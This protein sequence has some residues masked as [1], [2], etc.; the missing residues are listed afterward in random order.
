M[1]DGRKIDIVATTAP[2]APPDVPAAKPLLVL[3]GDR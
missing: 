2:I 3:L 1:N